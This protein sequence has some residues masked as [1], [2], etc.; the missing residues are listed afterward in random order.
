VRCS[1]AAATLP[2]SEA[3]RRLRGPRATRRPARP[4]AVRAAVASGSPR[5]GGSRR[6]PRRARCAP[7]PGPAREA[8]R[9]VAARRAAGRAR[10]TVGMRGSGAARSAAQA[11]SMAGSSRVLSII[12][13]AGGV[14]VGVR[15]GAR[16]PRRRARAVVRVRRQ[17][18]RREEEVGQDGERDDL[19]AEV[20]H[21]PLERVEL[22]EH[23]LPAQHGL[24]PRL[25]D[26]R[27]DGRADQVRLRPKAREVRV[28]GVVHGAPRARR[29]QGA[30]LEQCGC[31]RSS[32]IWT[33]C[34]KDPISAPAPHDL[35][36]RSSP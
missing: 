17:A 24:E 21:L 33:A 35:G 19:V 15:R 3:T 36:D 6:G 9:R 22:E 23:L 32:T 14:R 28:Q 1:T 2:A 12:G 26:E 4:R 10:R 31:P 18:L 34:L 5:A 20:V 29:R 25:A 16:P 27:F 8:R 13:T 11:S 30:P 7:R